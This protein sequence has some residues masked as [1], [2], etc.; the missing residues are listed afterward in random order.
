MTPTKFAPPFGVTSEAH[1]L[2]EAMP[3]DM[4]R[5][6]PVPAGVLDRHPRL[7]LDRRTWTS[8]N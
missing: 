6:D 1:R 5:R 2:G 7:D 4:V 3:S 8:V